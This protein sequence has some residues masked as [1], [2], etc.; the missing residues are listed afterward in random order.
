MV[1]STCL[2]L[3]EVEERKL[4]KHLGHRV[5]DAHVQLESSSQLCP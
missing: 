2:M 5:K 3:K 1:D 4:G